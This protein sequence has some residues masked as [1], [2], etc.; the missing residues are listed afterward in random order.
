MQI[1]Q[2]C[3]LKVVKPSVTVQYDWY[4]SLQV[5]TSV[6]QGKAGSPE[7]YGACL[8][9]RLP[10]RFYLALHKESWEAYA[11][12]QSSRNC[13]SYLPVQLAV[14]TSLCS[15]LSVRHRLNL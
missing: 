10:V 6:L 2:Y 7:I 14:L 15:T 9:E 5:R 4:L 3:C 11:W 8:L 1:W 13:L 12:M